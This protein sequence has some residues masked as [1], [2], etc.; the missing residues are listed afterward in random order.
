MKDNFLQIR[1]KKNIKKNQIITIKD[2]NI[3]KKNLNQYS[4]KVL[5]RFPIVSLSNISKNQLLKK[6]DYKYLKIGIVISCRLNSKRL[7]NKALLKTGGVESIQRC[8]NQVKFTGQKN[9]VIATAINEND[10]SLLKLAKKNNIKFY[11]GS[12]NNLILRN[13]QVA[14]KMNFDYFV[15]VTGDSPLVSYELINTMIKS[16]LINNYDY[17]Y[18]DNLPLGTR[19]EVIKTSAL[20]YLYK[21]TITDRYG[22]YLSLYFKNNCKFFKIKK[23]NLSYYPDYKNI[24]LNLDFKSDL[25]YINKLLNFFKNKKII[26]LDEVFIFLRFFHKENIFIKSKYNQKRLYKKIY[27]DSLIF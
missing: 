21:K 6:K 26:S 18:N 1:L 27:N 5:R 4:L 17:I 3:L 22:E 15:R 9:I 8:I 25:D 7:P 2:I 24:R 13:L 23:L 14:E 11:R 12:D 10:L 20:K 19:V 16:Q